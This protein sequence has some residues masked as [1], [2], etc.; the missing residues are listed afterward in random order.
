[1]IYGLD[2]DCFHLTHGGE[3]SYFNCHRCWLPQNRKFMQQKNAFKKDN[4]VTKGPPKHLSGP[5][6]ID[7]LDKLMSNP[8]RPGY[9]EGY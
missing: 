4:I 8:E 7:M 3:I 6:I 5:Q 9:F 2:T 1:L